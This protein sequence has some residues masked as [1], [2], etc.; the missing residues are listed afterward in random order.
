MHSIYWGEVTQ[1]ERLACAR[2]SI[3]RTII[4]HK[5][6]ASQKMHIVSSLYTACTLKYTSSAQAGNY[7]HLL[8]CTLC[9]HYDSAQVGHSCACK[10]FLL[11]ECVK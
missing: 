1:Q 8:A 2:V 11:C 9:V 3:L 6:C 10:P 5:Q 7:V 4:V